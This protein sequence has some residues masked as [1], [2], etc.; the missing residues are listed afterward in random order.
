VDSSRLPRGSPARFGALGHG[1][2]PL[3]QIGRSCDICR[4]CTS[5]RRIY[6]SIIVDHAQIAGTIRNTKTHD[7]L[8]LNSKRIFNV[9]NC[10]HRQRC[11]SRPVFPSLARPESCCIA[12]RRVALSDR[13]CLDRVPCLGIRRAASRLHGLEEC[14]C[15]VFIFDGLRKR[16]IQMAKPG[17]CIRGILRLEFG[18]HCDWKLIHEI[19]PSTTA[20]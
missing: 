7:H 17:T 18:I 13:S 20:G 5:H 9:H 14:D 6:S 16:C 4:F 15:R 3:A 2:R 12:S 1:L 10:I 19:I 11:R 8:T